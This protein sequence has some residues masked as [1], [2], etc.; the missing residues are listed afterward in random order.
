MA[1]PMIDRRGLL[2]LIAATPL[3]AAPAHAA[4]DS[5]AG[6][7]SGPIDK[8]AA[9]WPVYDAAADAP[10]RAAI[11]RAGY[12]RPEKRVYQAAGVT[13]SHERLDAWLPD[14]D[15]QAAAVRRLHARFSVAYALHEVHFERAF[16]DFDRTTAPVYV[17]LSLGDFDAHLQPWHGRLPLF[18]GL[19]GIV[20]YHG[21]QADL[22][23]LLDH[24]SYHL[25]QGQQNPKLSL[26]EKPPLFV[27]LW[28]EGTA[29]FVSELLN[30]QSNSLAVLL[31]DAPLAAATPDTIRRAAAALLDRLDS[32][33]EKDADRFFGAGY[34]GSEPARIGYLL[35]LMVARGLKS[36]YS[37]AALARLDGRTVRALCEQALETIVG[38]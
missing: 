16:P 1:L 22:A 15:R 27:T 3:L 20:E 10:D 9:F 14:F 37:P 28:M 32:T 7:A 26:D 36:R 21:A 12:F 23:V 2:R 11:L 19:D 33:R 34:E 18:I 31:N 30:P 5:D 25:Y 4:D 13:I 38:S 17:M 6:P 24:E 29:T 8:L 35:G